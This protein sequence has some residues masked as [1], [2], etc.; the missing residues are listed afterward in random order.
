MECIRCGKCCLADMIALAEENDYKLWKTNG[1]FDILDSIKSENGVW[2]GDCYISSVDGNRL[3]GCKFYI[4]N[5][6]KGECLI[7]EFRPRVC[8]DFIPGSSYICPLYVKTKE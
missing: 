2:A 6:G 3:L 1:R 4:F 5:N 7:Y 8:R